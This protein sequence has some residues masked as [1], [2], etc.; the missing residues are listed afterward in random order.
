[1]RTVWIAHF[2]S[3]CFCRPQHRSARLGGP[4]RE[5]AWHGQRR[6]LDDF[7][8]VHQHLRIDY[9]S[10]LQ[11]PRKSHSMPALPQPTATSER[12]MSALRKRLTSP[13][14]YLAILVCFYAAAAIDSFRPPRS[15]WTAKAY[16]QAVR[17]YQAYGRPLSSRYIKCRY[18]PTC[19]EYSFQAVE[20]WGIRHGLVL[21]YRRLRSC[22]TA[23]PPGTADPIPQPEQSTP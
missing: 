19:S 21:T 22:T 13:H 18:R 23:V 17:L 16:L 10:L 8:P 20:A 6:H 5:G 7:G 11:A 9:L 2:H 3:D 15:Q 1:M 12:Q 4:R 14:T